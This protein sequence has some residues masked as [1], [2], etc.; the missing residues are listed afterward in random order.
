MMWNGDF[1]TDKYDYDND[2]DGDGYSKIEDKDN[3][4]KDNY[5]KDGCDKNN[6]DKDKKIINSFECSEIF[7]IAA[8]IRS[9]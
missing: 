2:D 7:F 5:N 3:H 8:I 6:H 9:L 1:F 4:N